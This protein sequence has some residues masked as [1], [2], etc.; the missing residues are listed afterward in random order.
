MTEVQLRDACEEEM[1]A[2][3]PGG[4]NFMHALISSWEF[5][6]QAGRP[7][8]AGQGGGRAVRRGVGAKMS[9][10][11]RRRHTPAPLLV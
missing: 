6:R 4:L 9:R 1:Q 3:D 8:R 10:G 11:R 2:K 5:S 7:G